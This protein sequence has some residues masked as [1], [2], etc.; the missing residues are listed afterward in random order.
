[1]QI[2]PGLGESELF[3]SLLI[4]GTNVGTIIGGLVCGFLMRIVPYWYLWAVSLVAHTISYVM[5]C[6][7]HQGWLMM[8]SR[9]LAGYFAGATLTL[10]FS[11]FTDTSVLYVEELNRMRTGAKTE[12]ERVRNYLF[13]TFSVSMNLGFIL[14][15]GKRFVLAGFKIHN[16]C[17]GLT[18]I[19]A[20]FESVDQFRAIGWFNVAYGVVVLC[21]FVI[22]FRGE[23]SFKTDRL[24]YCQVKKKDSN[25]RM[26]NMSLLS[27]FISFRIHYYLKEHDCIPHYMP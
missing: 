12:S 2:E 23:M 26:R 27:L 15:P 3:Y 24:S 13:A 9:L 17:A 20:Q 5:Y 10:G 18:V 11:Y 21:V 6:V 14:G 22:L 7:V 1:M 19:V 16:F 4:S 25:C 8:I